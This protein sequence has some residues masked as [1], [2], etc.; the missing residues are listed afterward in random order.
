[1]NSHE[2]QSPFGF[3]SRRLATPPRG[4]FARLLT[5]AAGALLLLVGFM[6]SLVALGIVLVGGVLAIAYL[7][8]KTRHL[9]AVLGEQLQQNRQSEP[10]PAAM[11]RKASGR[12]VEGEVIGA[13]EYDRA[14]TA[15]QP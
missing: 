4:I 8:W 1:M 5:L 7:K 14:P 13:A 9:S 2:E 10:P 12:V 11:D 3:S 6:F 15:R